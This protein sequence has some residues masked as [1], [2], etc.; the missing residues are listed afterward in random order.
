M[1][2]SYGTFVAVLLVAAVCGCGKPDKEKMELGVNFVCSTL[3]AANKN[4]LASAS[5]GS[6]VEMGGTVFTYLAATAP[7]SHDLPPFTAAPEKP[8][9]VVVKPGPGPNEYVV[10]GYGVDLA[11]PLVARTVKVVP[12]K[13]Q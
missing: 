4:P 3:D 13:I 10:E 11:K 6:M 2:R 12:M 5:S 9:S 1:N 7:E 8:W